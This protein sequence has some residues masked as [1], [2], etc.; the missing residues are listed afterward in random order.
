MTKTP[1]CSQCLSEYDSRSKVP[2]VLPCGNSICAECCKSPSICIFCK[3]EHSQSYTNKFILGL[4][5]KSPEPL[6]DQQLEEIT[7]KNKKLELIIEKFREQIN[8][9]YLVIESEIDARTEKLID[10]LNRSRDSLKKQLNEHKLDA[11]MPL[12][13]I[14]IFKIHKNQDPEKL[15]E[16]IEHAFRRVEN[17]KKNL[18]KP[19]IRFVKSN[20]KM[21]LNS[22]LGRLEIV[23]EN[24]KLVSNST[25]FSNSIID[26]K[27]FRSFEYKIP[28]NCKNLI[29][30]FLPDSSL[31]KVVE[32][33]LHDN[34][35]FTL[36]IDLVEDSRIVRKI[37]ESIGAYRLKKVVTN[38]YNKFFLV[39]I[40]NKFNESQDYLKIYDENLSVYKTKGLMHS[41]QN[42]LMCDRFVY[43]IKQ[44]NLIDKYDFDFKLLGTYSIQTSD[45]SEAF[46]IPKNYY[47]M[48]AQ[49][50]RLFCL[51]V[52]RSKI[53][54]ISERNGKVA[55]SFEIEFNRDFCLVQTD[56]NDFIYVLNRKN[57]K[58]NVY[59]LDGILLV[60]KRLDPRRIEEIDYFHAYL[61]QNISILDKKN[62]LVH[63][64]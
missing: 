11:L 13:S 40:S 38:N 52:E 42:I 61:D 24:K 6:T 54:L 5:S 32:E 46:Y 12:D 23:N 17:L 14:P 21:D 1:S 26:F 59:N 33:G 62:R 37:S 50:D 25:F 60:Q 19:D 28:F 16:G 43:L 20:I 29:V 47:L 64:I 22:S 3:N 57:L 2:K 58:L 63:F 8:Q 9:Q 18:A 49:N 31:L 36:N 51:D 7:Q 10:D 53:K 15:I 41:P 44:N 30:A 45:R 34:F 56:S 39:H 55:K 4:L 48:Q 35:Q 27:K